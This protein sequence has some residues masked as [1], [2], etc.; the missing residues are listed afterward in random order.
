MPAAGLSLERRAGASKPCRPLPCRVEHGKNVDVAVLDTVGD[1]VGSPGHNQLACPV[2]A[3][4]SS[5]R[6][7]VLQVA[8][9]LLNTPQ[10]AVGHLL[11]GLLCE[12]SGSPYPILSRRTSDRLAI[13]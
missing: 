9:C 6:G 11:A 1:N 7:V 2:D 3:P 10:D 13:R 4:D 8:D 5:K 12:I